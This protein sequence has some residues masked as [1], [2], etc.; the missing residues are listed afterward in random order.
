MVLV[1]LALFMMVMAARKKDGPVA[2]NAGLFREVARL[3]LG[4]GYSLNALSG[5]DP[6]FGLSGRYRYNSAT[7]N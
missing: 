7:L 5:P 6:G 1:Q 4:S 3:F 2:C